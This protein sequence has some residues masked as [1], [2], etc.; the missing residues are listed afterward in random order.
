MPV[1]EC[2]H[3]HVTQTDEALARAVHEIVAIRWMELRGSDDLRQLLHIG[4]LYV[5]N[6]EA[7][8]RYIQ[9]PQ[10]DAQVIRR[11]VRFRVRIDRDRIDVIRVRVGVD[12]ARGCFDHEFHRLQHG[13]LLIQTRRNDESLTAM[14]SNGD[15]LPSAQ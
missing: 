4:R 13:Y 14:A 5:H 12:A 9:V 7:L 15:E 11:Q 2:R 1:T 8:I 10:V 6:V 3:P